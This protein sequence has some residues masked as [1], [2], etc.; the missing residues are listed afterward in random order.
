[1]ESVVD[2]PMAD[3]EHF[4]ERDHSTNGNRTGP[5]SFQT[6]LQNLLRS[7]GNTAASLWVRNFTELKVDAGR[8]QAISVFRPETSSLGQLAVIAC[9]GPEL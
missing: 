9:G 1:M 8:H 7:V 3:Q 2:K 4:E 6:Q 5:F